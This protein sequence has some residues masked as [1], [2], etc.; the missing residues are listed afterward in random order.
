MADVLNYVF[1]HNE[2]VE[3][4]IK[5]QEIREGN[6]GLYVEFAFTAS[7]V[8]AGPNDPNMMPAAIA[9]IKRIGI[10]KF[11]PSHPNFPNTVDAAKLNPKP[12]SKK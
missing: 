7:F 6:W 11:E 3:I 10:Q 2:L 1:D 8:G 9:A 5:K 4:L 12:K